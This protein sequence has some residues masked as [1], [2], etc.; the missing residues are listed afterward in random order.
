MICRLLRAGANPDI[1]SSFGTAREIAARYQHDDVVFA[2]DRH[3]CRRWLLELCIGLFATDFPVLVVLQIHNARCI[4]SGLHEATFTMFR[5]GRS[6]LECH[7]QELVS[8]EIAKM[9]KHYLK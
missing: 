3:K 7:L 6:L 8:W 1:V 5:P 2:I 9:V 4:V